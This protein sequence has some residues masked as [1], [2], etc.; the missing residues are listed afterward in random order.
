MGS[1]TVR[2]TEEKAAAV[3][4]LWAVARSRR[5]VSRPVRWCPVK[6]GLPPDWTP[7]QMAEGERRRQA[8][9]EFFSQSEA[10]E[11]GARDAPMSRID[12]ARIAA[13]RMK[14]EAEL[15]RYPNVIGVSEGIRM[16]RG[17]PTG[18]PCLVVYVKRKVP[19]ARL[20][21][22]EVLPRKIDG[23]PVDVV[24]V[25]AVEALSG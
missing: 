23:V 15:M 1:D 8:W 10:A 14:Y 20:G 18:E 6:R 22:G 25:G 16:K 3:E 17:K 9:E 24:E 5:R 21:K 4:W 11:K 12:D 13:L 19:R 2:V 7:A